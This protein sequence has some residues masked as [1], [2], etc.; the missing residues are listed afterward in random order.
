MN[1][2]FIVVVVMGYGW[3]WYFFFS[4]FFIFCCSFFVKVFVWGFVLGLQCLWEVEVMGLGCGRNMGLKNVDIDNEF[5]GQVDV[6]V[7]FDRCYSV[8]CLL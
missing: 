7:L 2:F 8:W 1:L 4:V 3:I 5:E 6:F